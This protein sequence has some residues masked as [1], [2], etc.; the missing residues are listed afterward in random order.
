MKT[1]SLALLAA[2]ARRPRWRPAAAAPTTPRAAEARRRSPRRPAA[3]RPSSR[4]SPTRRRRSSTTRSSR[5]SRRPAAGKGVA[6]TESFGASGDQSRAVEA[7]LPADV[8]AFSLE[9]D[10]TRL[11]KA[12]LVADDWA[13][14]AA[15]GPR[16]QL[17]R[18]ASSSA[19]ATRRTSRPGTTCSSPAS[20]SSRRTRSP[21][22][23]RSG[24]SWPPT[25]PRAA[26]ARTR[27]QGPRLPA[28]AD[29]QARHGPGQVRPRGAAELHV[30]QRRRPHLLRERG[31]HRPEEGPG[32]R[33]RHPRPDDPDREPDRRRRR[34]PSTREQAKAFVDYALSAP[35]QQNFADWGYRPVDEAV[36]DKNKDKFPDAERPV[37]DRR[38]RRL[39][40]GQRRVLRP[41]QGLGRRRSRRTRGSPLPSEARPHRPVRR[42]AASPRAAPGGSGALGLGIATL[43]LS[44]IVLLP[45]AAVVARSTDGGL[46]AFWDAV[47][48][49]QAVAALK[50]TLW[51]SL[52]VAAINAVAGTLDGLGARAR[53]LPRQRGHQRAHRPAVRAA[54]DRRRHHAARAL[55]ADAPVGIN[56]VVTTLGDPPG[57]AVRDAAVRRALGAAGAASSSTARWRRRRRRSARAR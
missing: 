41:R 56:V 27:R 28:R 4:S 46:G 48:S 43:W 31:D 8:V 53:P 3:A 5:T 33:L 37:H 30:G 38:P 14:N 17:R 2:R 51:T 24:T 10:M 52:V 40:E 11:V 39:A 9:P 47:T 42:R 1:R 54:D 22:A 26:A 21:R 55:R 50:L 18:L 20:R 44:V 29:H 13:D 34:S 19:R 7:G 49:R 12:G 23:R 36:L 6:F 32:G 15:Q 16:H 45:L 57:A 25:A 35:A